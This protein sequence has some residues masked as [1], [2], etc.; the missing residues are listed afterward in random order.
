[1]NGHNQEKPFFDR[2]VALGRDMES[3]KAD[4]AEVYAGAKEA[5]VDRKVLRHAV[6]LA[7]ETDAKRE[8]RERVADAAETLLHSLGQLRDTPLG[9]AAVVAQYV[10]AFGQVEGLGPSVR[11]DESQAGNPPKRRGRPPGSKN[12]P[13][14]V[15]DAHPDPQPTIDDDDDPFLDRPM[16]G[17]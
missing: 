4:I 17:E 2:L 13:K 12:R 11:L 8:E 7:L 15:L 6:K 10:A 9:D 3:L 5:E 16:P 1:M 14:A